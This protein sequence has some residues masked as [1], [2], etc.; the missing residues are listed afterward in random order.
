MFIFNIETFMGSGGYFDSIWYVHIVAPK[1]MVAHGSVSNQPRPCHHSQSSNI[2]IPFLQ[3][4]LPPSFDVATGWIITLPD[5]N[6]AP[7]NQWLEDEISF[8]DGPFSGIMFV[9]GR[10]FHNLVKHQ[11]NDRQYTKLS[12]LLANNRMAK[13]DQQPIQFIVLP[14]NLLP[15]KI[16][17]Q[18][19]H[20]HT[21][22]HTSTCYL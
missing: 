20:T 11:E 4:W 13:Y 3:E 5:T 16:S 21:Q 19:K 1:S 10:V 6:K 15:Q 8:G 2:D 7:L 22:R 12:S 18:K 17:F 9:S 14:Q